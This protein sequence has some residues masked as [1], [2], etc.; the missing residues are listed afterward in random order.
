M[1]VEFAAAIWFGQIPGLVLVGAIWLV[2]FVFYI[3]LYTRLTRAFDASLVRRLI[4]W[5]WVRTLCWTAR[6]V[7]LLWITATHPAI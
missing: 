5:Q 2:T 4:A 6:S 7:I 3:P 1:V